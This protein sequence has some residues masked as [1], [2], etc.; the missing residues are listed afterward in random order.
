MAK[1]LPLLEQMRANP[2]ADWTVSQVEKLA[3]EVG[4]HI[5][6]SKGGSHNMIISSPKEPF[7]LTVPFKRP[8]KPIY[9]KRLVS[10]ADVHANNERP[11]R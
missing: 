6:P 10:L 5:R 11:A 9:I 7:H 3:K 8:I 1:K 2:N 4:L